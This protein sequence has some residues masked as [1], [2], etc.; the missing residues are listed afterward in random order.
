MTQK[1]TISLISGILVGLLGARLYY[2]KKLPEKLSLTA[3]TAPA[4]TATP[5]IKKKKM[6]TV[7][8]ITFETDADNP[9]GISLEQMPITELPKTVP[10]LS[11]VVNFSTTANVSAEAQKIIRAQITDLVKK[12]TVSPG[13]LND[14]L[15][16]GLY[17]KMAGEYGLSKEAWGYAKKLQPTDKQAYN[18]LGDLYQYYL[19]DMANAEINWKKTIALDVK[20][21]AGYRNLYN[22]YSQNKQSDQARAVLESGLAKN[23]Q[24]IDL[25]VLLG[26]YYRDQGQKDTARTYYEKAL[27]EAKASKENAS[28]VS[29]IQAEI[30]RP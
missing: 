16:L 12:L 4:M 18:N 10:L 8:G 1:T 24:S 7:G 3:T 27:A 20:F 6:V 17:R 22:L 21:I 2:S 5:A 26:T 13:V 14:W 25:L 15:S 28:L 19:K 30:D 11:S 9:G 29:A 23:P